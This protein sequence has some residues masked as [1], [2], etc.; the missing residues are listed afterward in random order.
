MKIGDDVVFVKSWPGVCVGDH[1]VIRDIDRGEQTLRVWNSRTQMTHMLVF[2]TD[3]TAVHDSI[4]W[5]QICAIVGNA[6]IDG[7][8][9][10]QLER[11]IVNG[12]K[13]PTTIEDYLR[14]FID[15]LELHAVEMNSRRCDSLEEFQERAG[16]VADY[17]EAVYKLIDAGFMP[18][19][20]GL[21]DADGKDAQ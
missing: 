3:V 16:V 19:P 10:F 12:Y 20:V 15:E 14:Y 5:T 9:S 18:A 7:M 8:L 17:A 2:R 11:S 21:G 1:G 4:P 13:T 6:R